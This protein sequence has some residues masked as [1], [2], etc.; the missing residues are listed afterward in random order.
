MAF[1]YDGD[2][3]PTAQVV[4]FDIG[5][6][7]NNVD[8]QFH[9]SIIGELVNLVANI[10][11]P[12]FV[13]MV[14]QMIDQAVP[15]AMNQIINQMIRQMPLTIDVGPNLA[16]TFAIPQTPWVNA[17]YF[18]VAISGYIFFKP[19]PAPPPYNPG[20]CPDYDP[21][22]QKGI[23][24]FMTDYVIR[25][26]IDATFNAGIMDIQYSVSVDAYDLTF[27]C[28]ATTSPVLAFHSDITGIFPYYSNSYSYR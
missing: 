7:P 11:K 13:G 17:D 27:D 1:G 12:I 16:I 28:A 24:F 15:P 6:G 3:R 25:S 19:K 14:R 5:I 10:L 21:G 4:G 23:H 22:S 20:P 26:A 9:G 8:I 2:G 18:C